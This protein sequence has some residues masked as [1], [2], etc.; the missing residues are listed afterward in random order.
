MPIFAWFM[1]VPGRLAHRLDLGCLSAGS[2]HF[3]LR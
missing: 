3:F 1:S 2:Q